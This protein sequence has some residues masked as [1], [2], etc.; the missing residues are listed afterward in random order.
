MNRAL[1]GFDFTGTHSFFDNLFASS[2]LSPII[3]LMSTF[4]LVNFV[5]ASLNILNFEASSYAD[6]V[7]CTVF[8]ADSITFLICR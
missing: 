5:K 4:L 6:D 8:S 3:T 2:S 7:T 1:I